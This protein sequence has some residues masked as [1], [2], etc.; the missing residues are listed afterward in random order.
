M[1]SKK[2]CRPLV[3]ATAKDFH[4]EEFIESKP[5]V[6]NLFHSSNKEQFAHVARIYADLHFDQE[7]KELIKDKKVWVVEDMINGKM[8]SWDEENTFDTF[9]EKCSKQENKELFGSYKKNATSEGLDLHNFVKTCY[10]KPEDSVLGVVP[11]HF[12]SSGLNWL[13]PA[14]PPN[15]PIL[16]DFETM[17]HSFAGRDLG[18]VF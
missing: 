9:I 1:R 2:G 11:V 4:L 14:D 7:I 15:I 5:P 18:I 6:N 13:I 8:K 3:Y 17:R 16:I 10:M 12:D